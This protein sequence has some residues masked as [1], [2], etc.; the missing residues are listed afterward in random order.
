M[1]DDKNTVGLTA[2]GEAMP[3]TKP[4][5]DEALLKIKSAGSGVNYM[6]TLI[7]MVAI[8]LAVYKQTGE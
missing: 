7:A 5:C 2:L 1:I 3:K 6:V 8:R 4:I